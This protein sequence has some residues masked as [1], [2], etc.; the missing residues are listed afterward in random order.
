MNVKLKVLTAGVLFFT[1][2]ALVAQEVKKDTTSGKEKT[3]D[4]VVLVGF[5]RKVAVKEATGAIGKV[6]KEIADMSTGSV[7]KALSGKV[8]GVQTGMSTG[9]PG[10][11]ANI[12]IR[13]VSSV[14]GRN[15]PIVV[16]DGVRVA[17]GDL[18]RNTTSANI[19]ANFNE[20]DIESVTFL[21]DA[22]STAVYGADAGAGV[23]I[24]TT[25]SGKKGKARF[26]VNAETGVTYR[27][28][29]GH[30]G[31]SASEWVS[32]YTRGYLNANPLVPVNPNF[33]NGPK[34]PS[35]VQ[36]AYDNLGVDTSVSTDWQKATERTGGAFLTRVNASVSGGSDRL[37]YYSS[38]GYFNQEGIVR[39][40]AF[41]RISG[42][43]RVNYKATDRLTLS[44]DIQAS[45]GVTNTQPEGGAFS[46][47]ILARY[48]L[49]P[50]DPLKN[51]DGTYYFGNGRLS[52][53]F[54]NIAALQDINY[55]RANTARVFANIQ[56]DYKILKNLNYKFV[57]APEFINIEE[58]QYYSPLHGDG[59]RLQGGLYSYSTRY[60][61]FNLQNILS[62]DF[63]IGEKNNFNA[64]LIQ[65]AYKSDARLVGG[66]GNAVGTPNLQTLNNFIIPRTVTGE[67]TVTSRGGYAV[68][69][70]YDYDKLFL[71]DLSGRQDRV[72]NFWPD[73]KTGYF[74]SAGIG[75]DLARLE[76]LK[77]N[78]TISQ[79]KF[80]ASYGKV[81]N[82]PN[83]SVLPFTTYRY[84]G[85]YGDKPAAFV[86][87]VA[88]QDLEWETIKPFNVGF[89]LGLFNDRVTL[90][91]AFY[92]KKT[93]NMIYSVPLSMIQGGYS[94]LSTADATRFQN[95]GSMRN[96]GLEFTL[97]ARIINSSNVKWNV[98]A[99][100]STLS[101]KVTELY[102]GRDISTATRI[103]RE[104]EV[105]NS[106]YLRKWAGVDPSNGKPL[107]Y[108]N[109]VDGETTSDYNEA[110]QAVQGSPYAKIYGGLSTDFTYKGFSIDA[111]FSYG[112]GNKIYDSWA[113]YMFSDGATTGTYPGYRDQLD[114]WTPQNPNAKNP[115]PIDSRS[116]NSNQ[117]STRFLYKGDYVRLRSL[118]VSYT[119]N[120]DLLRDT[121][122]NSIQVYLVGN[123][124]WTYTFDK[125]FKFD[126]DYQIGGVTNFHLPPL[127]SYSIGVNLNF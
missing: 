67:K 12:Q 23:M 79:L 44:T 96:S 87:G 50:T 47:P 91:A 24:I 120:K 35:T 33:P 43:T 51:S 17:Q 107:W 65:E 113:R 36:D 4:E 26:N 49:Y 127:K 52:N 32:L 119:F 125:N 100:L 8:A 37:T 39:G 5:G 13:G 90:G 11:A 88:N 71:L 85:N 111:Q 101:N 89:D 68:T 42:T 62:Y 16:I 64:S 34:R 3:I 116:D 78:S 19:L 2:Q 117:A 38:L 74:W 80:S 31:L 108:K 46:N 118:K 28:V 114:Y 66:Y 105:L 61:N 93:T 86:R 97:A 56:A 75:V 122:I 115:A 27:A 124:I 1:G 20:A 82:L 103:I 25:K 95:V 83:A 92:H 58:D 121:G 55:Q 109:G 81:G 21:K 7:D 98:S 10:G 9:Q 63:K 53:S 126:P 6:G 15:N 102:Q 94:P 73:K 70:H 14:N 40:S 18:T 45:Y 57:F 22:V 77:D 59:Y 41:K 99:N 30:E 69:L 110:N 104:G 106:F 72:S 48:F 123:N 112:F 60:F 76:A 29:P 54:Y 84:T